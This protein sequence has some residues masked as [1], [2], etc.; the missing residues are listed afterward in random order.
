MSGL[1]SWRVWT[2]SPTGEVK[3]FPAITSRAMPRVAARLEEMGYRVTGGERIAPDGVPEPWGIDG[4][5][6]PE[7]LELA[8]G[9]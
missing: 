7:Q 6:A 1:D 4:N 9:Q 3:T 5:P 8:V 2:V